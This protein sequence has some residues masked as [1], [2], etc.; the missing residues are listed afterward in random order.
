MKFCPTQIVPLFTVMIGLGLTV[1]LLVAKV[2][3]TQPAVLVPANVKEVFDAGDIVILD[4]VE[5]LLQVY[6]LAPLAINVAVWPTQ[7][8]LEPEMLKTGNGLT[9]TVAV[10]L[11]PIQPAVLVTETE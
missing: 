6:V 11:V 7:I 8:A 2:C 3:D 10:L 5:A 9:F 4:A 1:K